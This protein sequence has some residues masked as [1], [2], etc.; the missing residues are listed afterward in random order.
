M[1]QSLSR[2]AKSSERSAVPLREADQ[3]SPDIGALPHMVALW[4]VGVEG[5]IGLFD[6]MV[7]KNRKPR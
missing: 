3:G 6:G 2:D 4:G 1:K 5:R 7:G